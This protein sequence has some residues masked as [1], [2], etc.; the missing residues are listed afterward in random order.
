MTPQTDERQATPEARAGEPGS[1]LK[2]ALKKRRKGS[3][4]TPEE[5]DAEVPV[6]AVPSKTKC[7]KQRKVKWDQVSLLSS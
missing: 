7:K 2:S 3:E 6:D 5:G 4:S 1:A